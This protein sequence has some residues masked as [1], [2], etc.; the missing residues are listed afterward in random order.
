MFDWP[1]NTH[2]FGGATKPTNAIKNWN[3]IVLVVEDFNFKYYLNDDISVKKVTAEV[4]DTPGR[5]ASEKWPRDA[6]GVISINSG[7]CRSTLEYFCIYTGDKQDEAFVKPVILNNSVEIIEEEMDPF[8]I[9]NE[10]KLPLSGGGIPKTA[11]QTIGLIALV[12]GAVCVAAAVAV[13]I[14]EIFLAKGRGKK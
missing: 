2:V 9:N 13:F 5:V 8:T 11:G 12:F 14:R 4:N 1:H 10:M 3:E 7:M 6:A